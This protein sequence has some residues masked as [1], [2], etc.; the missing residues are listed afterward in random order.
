MDKI[1][2]YLEYDFCVHVYFSVLGIKINIINTLANLFLN[3]NVKVFNLLNCTCKR[4]II[5][6][7]ALHVLYYDQM[8]V[9][10]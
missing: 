1:V 4:Y 7:I 6:Y 3:E 2:H 5:T 8:T 9:T 10:A